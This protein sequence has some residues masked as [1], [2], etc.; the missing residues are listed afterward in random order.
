M[1]TTAL[2]LRPPIHH[3]CLTHLDGSDDLL[4]SGTRAGTIR[5]YDRRQNQRK[6]VAEHRAAREGAVSALASRPSAPHELFFA[7]QSSIS[8]LDLRTGRLLYSYPAG[9]TG[10]HLVTIPP[11]ASPSDIEGGAA[12]QVGPTP[13]LASIS[14]DATLRLHSVQ[15]SISVGNGGGSGN[16]GKNNSGGKAKV[17]SMVGGIGIGAFVFRSWGTLPD[18]APEANL[19]GSK[20][21]EVD[22]D[23]GEVGEEVWDE[24]SEAG[25]NYESTDGEDSEEEEEEPPAP[26]KTKRR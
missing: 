19:K 3:L 6:P 23:D 26:K 13:G 16:S 18:L 10:R 17:E 24:M 14:A 2:K 8:A 11:P 12:L 4:C 1:P 21:A 7:D 15:P 9:Q 5:Q 20:G 25:N 22:S